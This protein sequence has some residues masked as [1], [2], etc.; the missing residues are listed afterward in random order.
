[1][2]LAG[3]PPKGAS[4]RVLMKSDVKR[5]TV[6]TALRHSTRDE[7]RRL[8][9]LVAEMLRTKTS[10]PAYE[11]LLS[12]VKEPTSSTSFRTVALIACGM[13]RAVA[14]STDPVQHV[15]P[16][17][18]LT[19]L[20]EKLISY[21]L[22]LTDEWP[23]DKNVSPRSEAADEPTQT[24]EDF[25]TSGIIKTYQVLVGRTPA[26]EE[27][28]IWKGHFKNGLG[29][30]EFLIRMANGAE[31][32]AFRRSTEIL[33]EESDG[34]FIQLAYELFH[35]R[36]CTAREIAHWEEKL[37][38]GATRRRDIV[39]AFVAD[40]AR[41]ERDTSSQPSVHDSHRCRILGSHRFLTIDDWRKRATELEQANQAKATN[42]FTFRFSIKTQPSYLVTAIASLCEAGEFIEQFMEN[43]VS[44]SCFR[45]YCELVIVDAD[46]PDDEYEVI[47]RYLSEHKGINYIRMNYRIG[48]Y[49]AWNVAV[50]AARGKY[51]TNTNLDDL[52]RQDSLELQAGVLDSLPFVDV[53]YQD[54]YYS[55]E[56]HLPFE[57]IAAF[58]FESS[59]P[60]V[61]P[62]NMMEFNSPHNA[63]MWRKCLHEELGYFNTAFKS[64]GDYEF[65]MRCLA[66]G[67][68]FYKL[69][70]PHVAYYQNPDGLSTR[71]DTR[72]IVEA[73]DILR[74]YGRKL[75]SENLLMPFE[76]FCEER[77]FRFRPQQEE[78]LSK[79]RYAATQRSLRNAARL[80]KYSAQ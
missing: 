1:M 29:F 27:I 75:I 54:F 57:Q 55:F 48:V 49:D 63:P 14:T 6:E 68:I 26:Q 21:L 40:A 38:S 45:D 36:G 64:A 10:Y 50:R 70:D 20:K 37:T 31:A 24:D 32:V 53:V 62:H 56:P 25:E 52:R 72:G 15:S 60:I 80:L 73:K 16:F 43:I 34:R 9:S 35:G 33:P 74:M 30:A 71:P 2:N 79:D 7:L 19:W 44:Q 12:L 47:K 17:K 3:T 13:S 5:R 23:G 46:S 11:Q 77:L 41:S 42:R 66:A 8:L 4:E 67:K 65:W 22:S 51:L 69:N 61:T 18:E 59:L 76:R 39:A 28:A 78:S 58:G